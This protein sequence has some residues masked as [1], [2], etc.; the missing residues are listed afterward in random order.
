MIKQLHTK[1]IDSFRLGHYPFLLIIYL[2]DFI[3]INEQVVSL[4]L[5]IWQQKMI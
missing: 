5:T 4:I 2:K 1:F 3:V